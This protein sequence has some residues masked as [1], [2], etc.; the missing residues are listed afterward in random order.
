MLRTDAHFYFKWQTSFSK[1]LSILDYSLAESFGSQTENKYC[2]IKATVFLDLSEA[3][4]DTV[5][6]VFIGRVST[7]GKIL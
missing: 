4:L 2:T 7:T 3:S 6:I 5:T 1:L